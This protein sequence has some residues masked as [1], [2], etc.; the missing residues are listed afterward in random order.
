MQL[1]SP[2]LFRNETHKSYNEN[3]YTVNKNFYYFV[4]EM[5]ERVQTPLRLDSGT[6]SDLSFVFLR[7]VTY[8]FIRPKQIPK[9]EPKTPVFVHCFTCQTVTCKQTFTLGVYSTAN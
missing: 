9:H 3:R 7:Q 2:T 4:P 6:V 1:Y 5:P 8:T